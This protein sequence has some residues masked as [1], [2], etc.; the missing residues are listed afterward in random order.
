[1]RAPGLVTKVRVKRALH[2]PDNTHQPAA[3]HVRIQ[4]VNR[5]DVSREGAVS[6]ALS[7]KGHNI[8]GEECHGGTNV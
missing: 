4:V 7:S 3:Y 2:V 6:T 1:M 8:Q 5:N